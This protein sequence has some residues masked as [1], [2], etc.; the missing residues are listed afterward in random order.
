MGSTLSLALANTDTHSIYGR[1][2]TNS[3]YTTIDPKVDDNHMARF[4]H[5]TYAYVLERA[6]QNLKALYLYHGNTR[7]AKAEIVGKYLEITFD[8][9]ESTQ[10]WDEVSEQIE[11]V[12]LEIPWLTKPFN[13]KWKE[14][15]DN[16]HNGHDV[17][18]YQ[19]KSI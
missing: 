7:R 11:N 8:S 18:V 4:K 9:T 10:L 6:H 1:F 16:A 3:A 17:R 19:K 14:V 15:Q 2:K 12:K 5:E 13:A